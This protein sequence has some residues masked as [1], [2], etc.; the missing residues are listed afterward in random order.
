M[1]VIAVK[2]PLLARSVEEQIDFCLDHGANVLTRW[3]WGFVN[4]LRNWS[5]SLTEKQRK[6]LASIYAKVKAARFE[7]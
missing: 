3:E 1:L 6:K 4:G 7:R 2:S 5:P